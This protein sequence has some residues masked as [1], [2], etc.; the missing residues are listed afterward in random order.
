[1]KRCL[2]VLAGIAIL[3]GAGC[4]YRIGSVMHPQIKTI[5]VAPVENDTI[6]YNL[7]AVVRKM[8]TERFMADGSLKVVDPKKADCVIYS[9]VTEVKFSEASWASRNER[10][11][12]FLPN[13]WSV[14]LTIEYSVIIPGRV[15][16]LLSKNT[17]TGTS[18]YETG[19]DFWTGRQSG[20][21]QAAYA[22]AK[23]LVAA[24]TEGW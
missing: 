23:N 15:T 12:I 18:Y 8:L 6:E 14:T 9:R 19:P 17:I 5:G 20:M 4:G 7:A 1:M 13:E 22:G 16:P 11:D 2:I 21:E 3:F 24:V 10:D